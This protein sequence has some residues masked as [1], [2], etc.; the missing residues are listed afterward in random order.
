MRFR[1]FDPLQ[2]E[3]LEVKR[4][5]RVQETLRKEFR[6]LLWLRSG[7]PD[8]DG[9]IGQLEAKIE[10]QIGWFDERQRLFQIRTEV[11]GNGFRMDELLAEIG[12]DEIDRFEQLIYGEVRSR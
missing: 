12:C 7:R 1:L 11:A 2:Y 6:D 4:L 10:R 9:R 5:A 3:C 8:T